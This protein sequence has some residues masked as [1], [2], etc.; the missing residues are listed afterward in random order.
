M[1]PKK[2][3]PETRAVLMVDQDMRSVIDSFRQATPFM[4][5]GRSGRTQ[6]RRE[7]VNASPELRA[8]VG[9]LP[10]DFLETLAR[11]GNKPE[12]T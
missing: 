6:E 8:L 7:M 10:L 5:E 12:E 3:S 1:N 4:S 9:R 2:I 11:V